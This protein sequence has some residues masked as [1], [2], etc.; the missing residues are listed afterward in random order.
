MCTMY[1]NRYLD[2]PLGDLTW[3][4]PKACIKY[5]SYDQN[6]VKTGGTESH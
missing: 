3:N 5:R 6:I 4:D 1:L 2:L